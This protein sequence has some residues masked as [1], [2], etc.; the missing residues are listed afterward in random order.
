MHRQ[1]EAWKQ[2]NFVH[3]DP[4]DDFQDIVKQITALSKAMPLAK[5]AMTTI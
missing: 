5:E 3:T 1:F 4:D 2:E